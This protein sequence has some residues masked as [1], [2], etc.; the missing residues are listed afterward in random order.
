ML[1]DNY[2]IIKETNWD[3]VMF[4]FV[5]Y[6]LF[7]FFVYLAY[8]HGIFKLPDLHLGKLLV[9]DRRQINKKPTN[10]TI[11][12]SSGGNSWLIELWFD[13]TLSCS[14]S[15]SPL[16]W[17]DDSLLSLSHESLRDFDDLESSFTLSTVL[18]SIFISS[19][20]RLRNGMSSMSDLLSRW[21]LLSANAP[22]FW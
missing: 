2:L 12:K 21:I 9:E 3:D 15:P 8:Q 20:M 6:W 1:G 19:C 7:C 18:S 14:F 10:S 13:N 22:I 16:A 4:Y 17:L 5:S 11:T